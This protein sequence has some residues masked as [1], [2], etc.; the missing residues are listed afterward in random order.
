MNRRRRM[1]A[2]LVPLCIGCL[3]SCQKDP[4]VRTYLSDALVPYIKRVAEGT[5]N[6]ERFMSQADPNFAASNPPVSPS[7]PND[8]TWKFCEPSGPGDNYTNPPPP[9]K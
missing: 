8:L 2:L 3:A 6:L 9:P 1:T 5:C 7:D 4:E